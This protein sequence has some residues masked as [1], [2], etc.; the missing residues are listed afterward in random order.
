MEISMLAPLPPDALAAEFDMLTSRAGVDVPADRR[1]G[2]LAA[3]ADFRSQLQLLHGP[4][5][6]LAEPSNTFTLVGRENA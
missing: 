6:Q 5:T 4:R 3:Y 2:I 1:A